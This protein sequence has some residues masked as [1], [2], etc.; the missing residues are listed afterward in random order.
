MELDVA[1]AGYANAQLA[2]RIEPILQ[3]VLLE[4]G[5]AEAQTGGQLA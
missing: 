3:E 2:Q 5:L 4:R 1:W